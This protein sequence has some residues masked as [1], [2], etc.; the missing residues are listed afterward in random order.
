MTFREEADVARATTEVVCANLIRDES[1]SVCLVR[2]SKPEALGRWSLPA[3][4][5]EVGESLREAAAR[6][7]L[8]ETGLVV[9][10]GPLIGIYHSPKTLEGGAAVSFVFESKVVG[11]EV[12][13]SVD[14]PQVEFFDRARLDELVDARALR[15]QHASLALAA[16]EAGTCLSDDIVVEVPPSEPPRD[17][18]PSPPGP[19]SAG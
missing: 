11:G 19:D 18:L 12:A 4:R 15:G 8:E 13:P 6:E 17:T 1:G 16:L 10:V 9:D 14:H 5:A 2:E 3:G 7:A